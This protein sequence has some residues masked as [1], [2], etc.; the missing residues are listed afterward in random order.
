MLRARARRCLLHILAMLRRPRTVQFHWQGIVREL[1]GVET[2]VLPPPA[3]VGSAPGEM[4]SAKNAMA[5]ALKM[6]YPS[7][8]KIFSR[9]K[10][11]VNLFVL[12]KPEGPGMSQE[13]ELA[14]FE[15]M[16][17]PHLDA[18]HNLARWLAAQ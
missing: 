8:T 15:A 16:M 5:T 13:H 1:R 3:A 14:S 9:A 12:K 10:K 11:V 6:E 2:Q 18:A 17:L 4:T 7:G